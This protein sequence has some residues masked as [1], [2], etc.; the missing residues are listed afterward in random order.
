[1]NADS[2]Q[3]AQPVQPG[4]RGLRIAPNFQ[5][6]LM[7]KSVRATY[8]LI[9]PVG[10]AKLHLPDDIK[11]VAQPIK[12]P[13]VNNGGCAPSGGCEFVPWQFGR[14][15][16]FLQIDHIH[17]PAARWYLKRGYDDDPAYWLEVPENETL[18]G[19]LVDTV[20][21][22]TEKSWV[23]RGQLLSALLPLFG[24][25]RAMRCKQRPAKRGRKP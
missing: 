20:C 12:K 1:M 10:C 23:D 7:A 24:A 11:G 18:A 19:W 8:P 14:E 5:Q 4:L 6:N 16:T 2:G 3:F 17:D 9:P 22:L 21:H 13:S 15:P 25:A